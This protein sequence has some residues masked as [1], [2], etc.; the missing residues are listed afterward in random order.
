MF[1]GEPWPMNRAGIL[2]DMLESSLCVSFTQGSCDV[3]DGTS[4]LVEIRNTFDR[5]TG[6]QTKAIQEF[7]AD[8]R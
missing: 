8:L 6:L 7:N 5:M 4:T 2:A 1:M 3:K